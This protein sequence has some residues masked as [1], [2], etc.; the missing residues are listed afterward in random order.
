VERSADISISVLIGMT[1]QSKGQ[2][3]Q[4]LYN[5]KWKL[6]PQYKGRASLFKTEEMKK[7]VARVDSDTKSPTESPNELC[8]KAEAFCHASQLT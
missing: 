6:D 7:K 4:C 1:A 5:K 3:G 8:L 2:K